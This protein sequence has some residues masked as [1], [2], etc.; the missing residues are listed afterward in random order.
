MALLP[1]LVLLLVV[2]SL[3]ALSLAATTARL[4]L[5]GDRRQATEASLVLETAMVRARLQADSVL[6]TWPPATVS[7]LAPPP[8][9]GWEVTALAEREGFSPVVRLRVTV[10]RRGASGHPVA[11][12]AGTLLLVAGSADTAIVLDNRPRF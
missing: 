10:L 12:R 6:A 4:R 5:V 8:V 11:A 2:E 3:A 9:A 1:A 7:P